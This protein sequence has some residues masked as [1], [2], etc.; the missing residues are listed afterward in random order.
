MKQIGAFILTVIACG[1]V[2][3]I[4]VNIASDNMI[5]LNGPQANLEIARGQS[6]AM[7]IDAQTQSSIERSEMRIR[8]IDANTQSQISKNLAHSALFTAMSFAMLPYGILALLGVLG[9]SIIALL[10]MVIVFRMK[11]KPVIHTI[12]TKTVIYLP[13]PNV[14]RHEMWRMI[15]Q[16]KP[17]LIDKK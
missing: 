8:E 5:S 17:L 9:L 1:I 2:G 6:R 15:A 16:Q 12:E 3:L 14:S 13:S 10:T 4:L 7:V 11:Q